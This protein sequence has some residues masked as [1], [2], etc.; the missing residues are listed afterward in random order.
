MMKPSLLDKSICL[1]KLFTGLFDYCIS[2]TRYL[3]TRWSAQLC[4]A[5]SSFDPTEL[6]M[7]HQALQV[8][9]FWFF[10]HFDNLK[11]SLWSTFAPDSTS[12]SN[13]QHK[14]CKW[15]DDS[16]HAGSSM[17]LYPLSREN[18][19]TERAINWSLWTTF[20]SC[21]MHLDH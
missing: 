11:A 15:D 13:G 3:I 9:A 12:S 6:L 18:V 1:A 5:L 17:L 10:F 7:N 4:S 2:P 16:S 8:E 20:A 14:K 21:C 19:S